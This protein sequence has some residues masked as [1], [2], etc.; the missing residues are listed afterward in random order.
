MGTVQEQLFTWSARY[1]VGIDFADVQ[2]QQLADIIN[3]LHQAL[4]EGKEKTVVGRTLDELIRCSKAH[5]AAEEKVLESCGYPEANAHHSEHECLVYSIL[6]LYQDLM[7]DD[8]SLTTHSV[9]FLKDWLG[10]EILNVDM[11][12]APFLKGHGVP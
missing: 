2:H 1:Q 11:K 7:R 8:A 3:R 6:K 5:F 12:C 4:R 10:Q 9:D